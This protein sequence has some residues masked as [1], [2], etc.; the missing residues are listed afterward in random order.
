MRVVRDEPYSATEGLFVPQVWGPLVSIRDDDGVAFGASM[1]GGDRLGFHRWALGAAYDFSAELPSALASYIY[2]GTAPWLV[3]AV[4]AHFGTK[5]SISGGEDVLSRET[6]ASLDLLRSWY[7]TTT[8]SI[9][10][11]YADVLRE[12][13]DSGQRFDARRFTG[14]SSSLG[15]TSVDG[16]AHAGAQRGFATI[17]SAAHFPEAL[18]ESDFSITDVAGGA[19]VWI[20]LPGSRR[21]SFVVSGR[22]RALAGAPEGLALLQVGGAGG[23]LTTPG[24]TPVG[25]RS[26]GVLPPGLRFYEPLRGYE[27]FAIF[28]SRTVTGDAA[29]RYPFIIDE[30]VASTLG[31]LPSGLLRQVDVEVFAS[32]AT[33]LEQ[34]R[35]EAY[36]VGGAVIPRFALWL[37]PLSLTIQGSRRLSY[38]EE[39]AAFIFLGPDL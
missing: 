20:P 27:D 29:Y 18:A 4:A 28:A 25:E 10:A 16:T 14:P 15:F 34:G 21:H 32:A 7:G 13:E 36:A 9:G 8:Y 17:A 6:V 39:W 37:V 22:G 35:D 38:D 26:A 5:E 31:F 19:S 2:S 12:T 1:L 24:G 33:F 23:A 30:G 3:S 11:R